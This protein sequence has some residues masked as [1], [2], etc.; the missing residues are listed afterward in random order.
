MEVNA[1]ESK[2]MSM[3]HRQTARQNHNIMIANKLF[4]K[5]WQ[6]KYL[7]MMVRN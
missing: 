7:G 4:M 5:V 1:G 2:Y 3:A 6:F